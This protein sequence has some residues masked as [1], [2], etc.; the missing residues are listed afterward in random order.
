MMIRN[1]S[2]TVYAALV[3]LALG[4]APALAANVDFDDGD[5][6]DSDWN[7]PLNWSNDAVPTAVDNVFLGDAFSGPITVDITASPLNQ[8]NE[9]GVGRDQTGTFTVNHSAGALVTNSWTN[10]GQGFGSG[11]SVGIYNLSGGSV[12]KNGGGNNVLGGFANARGELHITNDALWQVN[13]GFTAIG[14]E[15]NAASNAVGIITVADTG[16][17]QNTSG[18]Q[19]YVG[20][21]G[22]G[23]FTHDSS[24]TST[25]TGGL[26]IANESQGMGTVTI[27]AG[28]LS[29]NAG[30]TVNN[31]AGDIQIGRNNTTNTPV[32]DIN[33]GS[34]THG[35]NTV[36]GRDGQGLIDVSGGTFSTN[37]LIVGEGGANVDSDLAVSGSGSLTTTRI[38]LGLSGAANGRVE[39]TGSNATVTTGLLDVITTGSNTISWIADALGVSAIDVNGT[40]DLDPNPLLAVDL[41]AYTGGA[42]VLTLIDNDL[43]DAV[44]GTFSG[45]GEGAAVAGTGY[46]GT[47]N[48]TYINGGNDVALILGN[49]IPA[50][51]AL[52]AG[53]ALIGVGAM[54]RRR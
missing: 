34:V 36:I 37:W 19:L 23:S 39:I 42:G 12:T 50:P 32:L 33:G 29:L 8:I 54:R 10:L 15:T 16:Q 26:W 7:S 24:N 49:V 30:N 28:V 47:V 14:G 41:S 5:G 44:L 9:L 40:V 35:R 38:T 2:H 22:S 31:Q 1:L 48:I 18:T 17:F 27:N 25:V 3:A 6:G 53:L 43:A 11:D 20:R 4:A 52:P 13:T 51:A 45:L 46:A 21:G